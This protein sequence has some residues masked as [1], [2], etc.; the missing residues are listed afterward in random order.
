MS[1]RNE[2]R[3]TDDEQFFL[4]LV[5]DYLYQRDTVQ[6]DMINWSK[7]CDLAQRHNL[8]GILFYQ[9][10]KFMPELYRHIFENRFNSS[11][12][13]YKQRVAIEKRIERLFQDNRIKYF[14]VKGTIIADLYPFSP[15]RTMG[16]SDFIVQ[17]DDMDKAI[18][19]LNKH[20][21][22]G[23]ITSK[24]E[25]GCDYLGLHF[26]IHDQLIKESE[27]INQHQRNFFSNPFSY[28]K[29]NDID[30]Q[31][32]YI[33]LLMHI[34]KHII[35]SGIGLR[36]FLDL[37]IILRYAPQMDWKWIKEQLKRMRLEKFSRSCLVIVEH[38]FGL[39]CLD[40]SPKENLWL[41]DLETMIIRGGV[42]GDSS[43][44]DKDYF[45]KNRLIMGKGPIWIKRIIILFENLYP[46]Y[47]D[48]CE[49]QGNHFLIKHKFLLPVAWVKRHFVL[50]FRKNKSTTR[51]TI[52]DVFIYKEDI[53]QRRRLFKSIGL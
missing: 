19:L 10:K 17:S 26:E 24:H 4:R 3:L 32:H 34:R 44:F 2:F 15:C 9:C 31:F 30:L 33:F 7:V 45:A 51:K 18:D 39:N 50:L 38:F 13:L 42:F 1:F 28:V 40:Y 23:R 43:L 21:C 37:A 35:S 29:D 48:M 36:Q 53:E 49:Y 20:G 41:E 5:S 22:R 11:I 52:S 8:D 47:Q 46:S 14:L 25:W 6:T 16:D 27:L 12:F